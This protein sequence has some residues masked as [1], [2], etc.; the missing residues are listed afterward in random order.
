MTTTVPPAVV[1]ADPTL[2]SI[3]LERQAWLGPV[4]WTGPRICSLAD[5]RPPGASSTPSPAVGWGQTPNRCTLGGQWCSCAH[6]CPVIP[7]LSKSLIN[8]IAA[9]EG[10]PHLRALFKIKCWRCAQLSHV[11]HGPQDMFFIILG[12]F[13]QS[14]RT[15][16]QTELG[17]C[18][19]FVLAGRQVRAT[20]GPGINALSNAFLSESP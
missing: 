2:C 8:C 15:V 11:P 10:R 6:S 18:G 14:A 13:I 1:W 20:S 3:V 7:Q 9:C 16:V 4:G 19:A 17:S 5:E 12:T